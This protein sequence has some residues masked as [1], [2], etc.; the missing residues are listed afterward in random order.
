MSTKGKGFRTNEQELNKFISEHGY[1]NKAQSNKKLKVISNVLLGRNL[2]SANIQ[3]KFIE[4]YG[5]LAQSTQELYKK[6]INQFINWLFEQKR[7]EGKQSNK[8]KPLKKT[9][10]VNTK[11]KGLSDKELNI[12]L[13]NASKVYRD[14][15]VIQH[16]LALR[17]SELK[18]VTY[19]AILEEEFIKINNKGVE[20]TVYI[21]PFLKQ[22]F[23]NKAEKGEVLSQETQAYQKYLKRLGIKTGIPRLTSHLLRHHRATQLLKNGVD[24]KTISVVLGHSNISVTNTYLHTDTETQ[25]ASMNIH[26]EY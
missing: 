11:K 5:E 16:S 18:Q 22:K 4:I 24:I 25:K 10:V 12:I 8:P 15:I 6:Y 26:F 3:D 20:R 23:E 2:N 9:R 21:P 7:M 19:K 14:V 17:I 13:Q 1:N